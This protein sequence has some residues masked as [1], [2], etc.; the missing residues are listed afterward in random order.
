MVL[1]GFAGVVVGLASTSK[2]TTSF[3]VL[4][5]VPKLQRVPESKGALLGNQRVWTP[6]VL[7]KH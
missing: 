5:G 6:T 1:L 4:G 7:S 3:S 2:V